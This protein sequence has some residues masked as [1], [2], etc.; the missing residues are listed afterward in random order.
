M[1]D[2]ELRVCDSIVINATPETIFALLIDPR[3]HYRFDGSETVRGV[4]EAPET[5]KLG[6]TFTMKMR[7]GVPYSITST[8]VEYEENLRIAW[9]HF[10]RHIWRYE[11]EPIGDHQTK[12]T[13][14]FDYAPSRWP[15]GLELLGYPQKHRKN[16]PETL[17]R[18][19][20]VIESDQR[21]ANNT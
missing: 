9:Q 4:L 6:A 13:E 12:V 20:R 14:T 11:L 3:E 7:I 16:I 8:V 1:S 19:K 18:L 15:R 2:K 21:S 5:L 17:A 10:G